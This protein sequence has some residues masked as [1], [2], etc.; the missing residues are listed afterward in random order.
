MKAISLAVPFIAAGMIFAQTAPVQQSAPQAKTQ[1]GAHHEHDWMMRRLTAN[2]NLSTDQQA[3][4]HA[5]FQKAREETRALGPQ[6]HAEHQA[7]LNAV[8]SDQTAQIDKV[9]EQNAQLN[10]K[11]QAIHARSIA[12]FRAILNPDQQTK[13]DRH[14]EVM[15]GPHM[16]ARRHQMGR[17]SETQS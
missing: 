3:K 13:L 16:Q 11:A 15:F 6:L 5:I 8:K 12:E 9:I 4:A 10:A 14:L 7:V 2:L 17:Q 1:N